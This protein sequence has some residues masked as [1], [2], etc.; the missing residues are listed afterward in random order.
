METYNTISIII[1]TTN[2]I[3]VTAILTP[4]IVFHIV[5][6]KKLD[7]CQTLSYQYAPHSLQPRAGLGRSVANTWMKMAYRELSGLI[8]GKHF[9]NI[10]TDV[11]NI[12]LFDFICISG[13][14]SFRTYNQ[15]TVIVK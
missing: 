14:N 12:P 3:N 13:N 9:M 15:E 10:Y 7:H 1:N 4:S 2:E 5:K 6:R 8:W 11:H